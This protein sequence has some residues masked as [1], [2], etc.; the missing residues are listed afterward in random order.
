[1]NLRSRL[2]C[3]TIIT[4]FCAINSTL[5]ASKSAGNAELWADSVMQHLSLRQKIAQLFCPRLDITNDT[6]GFNDIESHFRK[7]KMGGLLLGKGTIKSYAD[8]INFAQKWS[9]IPV[10]VTLDGE[11][12]PA[13]RVTDAP[14]FASNMALGACANEALAYSYGKEVARQCKLLGIHVNFAPVLDV[15]SNPNNPVIGYRSFGDNAKMVAKLGAAY[16]RGLEDGGI[17]AVGKHFPGHGDT[18]VD[19]H[20]ALPTVDHNRA[21][22]D[23][24]DMMPFIVAAEAG[25]NGIMIGHIRVPALD[26]SGT[27][28]SMSKN[29][30]SGILVDSLGFNGL[31]FT[32]A[33]AMKG[34]NSAENNCILAFNAGADVLLGSS[35]PIADLSAMEKAAN[36]GR[37]SV[38]QINKKCR[39]LLIYKYNYIGA[40]ASYI[41]AAN[42]KNHIKT[43]D[44][45]SLLWA[46]AR[47]SITVV[48]GELKPV[49]DVENVTIE[50]VGGESKIMDSIKSKNI[51]TK[52]DTPQRLIVAVFNTTANSKQRF[53]QLLNQTNGNFDAVF[54]MNPYKMDEYN[55]KEVKGAVITPCDN[56]TEQQQAVVDAFQGKFTPK[57]KLPVK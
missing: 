20:K 14:R 42:A 35:N 53:N 51:S 2:I 33:L 41:D 39:K 13:M 52:P 15:N 56:T 32:D 34:A 12:G 5:I 36:E 8:L 24:I 43:A 16:C 19:S 30:T 46:I 55:Y 7:E 50:C 26:A 4:V 23:S 48:S 57:G 9:D 38:D 44:T 6:K 1:M 10:M 54:F 29:I 27:P 31:I 17:M 3:F 25:M 11:W 37:I 22:L 47:E 18:S 21:V 28:A 40:D 49:I 45:D